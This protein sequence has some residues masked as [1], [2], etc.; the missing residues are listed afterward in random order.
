MLV[1]LRLLV[2][3]ISN[4]TASSPMVL[5]EQELPLPA[6]QVRLSEWRINIMIEIVSWDGASC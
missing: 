5:W 3:R 6:R 4:P 2:L 1:V